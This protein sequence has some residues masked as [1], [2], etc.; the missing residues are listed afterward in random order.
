MKNA[1][2]DASQPTI[3]VSHKFQINLNVKVNELK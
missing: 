1:T 2:Y 3:L